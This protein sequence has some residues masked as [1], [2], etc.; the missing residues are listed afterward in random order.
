L[1]AVER[2]EYKWIQPFPN[3]MFNLKW[4][5]ENRTDYTQLSYQTN[6]KNGETI[7]VLS[8]P[9]QTQI[10]RILARVFDQN[11]FLAEFGIRSLSKAHAQ[12]P[13]HFCGGEVRYEP[14]E[15]ESK[16][17]G[18][19]SNWRGPIWFPT[20]FLIVEALRKLD[21]ALGS[22][23]K[24]DVHLDNNSSPV[25]MSLG[26][27]A[28]ELAIRMV[29]LFLPDANHRRPIYGDVKQFQ[30]N[31]HWQNH[32][33]FHEYFHAETGQGLG[34]SHQTWTCL[35]ATLIDEWCS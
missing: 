7:C 30:K 34:A 22:D 24:I 8:I 29:R 18:G 12:H 13:F 21:K 4:F 19:N 32:L 5:L 28:E 20:G 35:V 1:F 6:L 3:F 2:L 33:L 14:A 23:F 31:P 10:R 17:K 11:E 9:N 15:A 16:L 26:D 25:S 27:L